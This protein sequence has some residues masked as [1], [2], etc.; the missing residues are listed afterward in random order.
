MNGKWIWAKTDYRKDDYAEFVAP[1]ETFGVGAAILRI[2]CD[3]IYAAYVNGVL[4]AFSQCADFP[5]YKFCDEIDITPHC[6][7]QNDL[8]VIVWH[9]GADSQTYICDTAGVLFEVSE[10]GKTLVCSGTDTLSRIQN[11]YKNGY[12]KTITA[13]L[14]YSFLYD[15]TVTENG[16][17]PSVEMPK[18]YTL[19][20]RPIKPLVLQDRL[21]VTV[22]RRASSIL[23]DIGKEVA[24]FLELDID[25][26]AEQKL[27]ICFGEHIA[28]GGVRRKIGTR[29]FSV[30][31]VARVGRNTYLNPLRRIAGRYLEIFCDAE[32]AVRYIGIR[33]VVYPVTVQSVSFADP[34]IQKIYDVCVD[35]LRLCMHEHYEDCPW[36]EQALYAMDSRNQMLCGYYAFFG[37][38]YQRH[39]LLLLAKSLR[40]DG[41]LSICAP[42]GLDV[43]IPFFSLVYILQVYEYV[44][45]TDDRSVLDEV[46]EV[47]KTIIDT[48]AC[49]I[50]GS[51][52][53][54][55]FG[56]PCW[57]FYEW[58]DESHNDWQIERKPTDPCSCSYDL[59]LNCMYAYVLRLYG[60][61]TGKSVAVERM[62][63]AIRKTFGRDGVFALS[64]QTNRY[65]QLGNALAVL[66]GLGDDAL[67]ARI[68]SDRAMIPATLSMKPFVYDALLTFGDT[69]KD[70]ILQN[71]RTTYGKMLQAEATSFWETEKGQNDFDGAGSLCHG[72]SAMP[73]Y[74]L[75]LLSKT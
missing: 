53:V 60:R 3:G 21:P 20:K 62:I 27:T 33:P 57:N 70:Y 13:Q 1:F 67:A 2:A 25:S 75:R 9:L 69:Y 5:W 44:A 59:I 39:N 18:P 55:S 23:I 36:R 7:R 38:E 17:A 64:T 42:S 30:E 34:S 4:V 41:L 51:G 29:D 35:T 66:I 71:I 15:G 32:V 46:G 65:S 68:V 37:S 56:Y 19:H 48:F 24:G 74:Y 16:Y 10:N 22:Q 49:K 45:H 28:D 52:L 11:R 6:K 43:P 31:Y 40:K 73:V 12:C 47:V 72:W 61:L 58:A 63:D 26:K 54:P 14:G 50:D 8:T